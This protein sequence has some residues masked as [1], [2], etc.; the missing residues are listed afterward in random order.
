MEN[1][2]GRMYV[3]DSAVIWISLVVMWFVLIFI[4]LQVVPLADDFLTQAILVGS[5]ILAGV[6]ATSALVALLLHLH[7]ERNSLY[8]GELSP[9]SES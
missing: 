6:F 9:T 3:I 2:A 4:L 7:R 8:A 1:R 5:A